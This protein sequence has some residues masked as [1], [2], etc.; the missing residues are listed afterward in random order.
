VH[1]VELDDEGDLLAALGTLRVVAIRSD[2]GQ[3]DVELGRRVEPS[4]DRRPFA[5][6]RGRSSGWE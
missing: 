3:E 2:A 6:G 5:F 1:R 4:R